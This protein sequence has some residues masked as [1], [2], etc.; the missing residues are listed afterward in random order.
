MFLPYDFAIYLLHTLNSMAI[1]CWS[2]FDTF[3]YDSIKQC[4]RPLWTKRFLAEYFVL[5]YFYFFSCKLQYPSV[6]LTCIQEAGT[7]LCP[8]DCMLCMQ[9]RKVAS[10]S[11]GPHLK[12]QNNLHECWV[13]TDEWESCIDYHVLSR[14]GAA[15]Q[16]LS[17]CS[18]S[19][20]WSSLFPLIPQT[21]TSSHKSCQDFVKFYSVSLCNVGRTYCIASGSEFSFCDHTKEPGAS[22]QQEIQ[23]MQGFPCPLFLLVFQIQ[24]GRTWLLLAIGCVLASQEKS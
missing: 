7:P 12:R 8:W 3:L 14:T 22:R 5:E 10:F 23:Q 2:C 6:W 15:G 1:L 11:T 21:Q 17:A 20:R 19:N 16:T 9:V 18:T 4:C 13:V 24:A